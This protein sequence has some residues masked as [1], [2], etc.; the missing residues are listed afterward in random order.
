MTWHDLVRRIRAAGR[1]TTDGEAE[2][3][4]RAVLAALGGHVTGE[5]RCELTALLPPEAGAVLAGSIPLT[6]PLTAP[7]F[8]EAVA[9]ALDT[10]PPSARWATGTVLTELAQ[11]AGEELTGRILAQLPRGYALLF[12]R[13][14]LAPAA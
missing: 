4:L 11:T 10:A 2:D 6:Q 3:V 8:V 12:G 9:T 5:E 7:Q 1:Y 13:V 14:E